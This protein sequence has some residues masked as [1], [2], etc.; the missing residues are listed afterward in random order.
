MFDDALVE[1]AGRLKT[2]SKYWMMGTLLLN[3]GVLA[4]F[5]LIPLLHPEALS[6]TAMMPMLIAP[7][8]PA[9]VVQVETARAAGSQ[10]AHTT[11]LFTAP[12]TI[13]TGIHE[14]H[15][16]AP[17]PDG[18]IGVMPGSGTDVAGND[19]LAKMLGPSPAIVVAKVKPPAIPRMSSGITNGNLIVKTEPIYPAIAKAAGVQGTVILRAI[20]SKSGTIE[21]LV[22]QSGPAMLRQAALD[23][24]R[25]WRYRPFLLNGEPT[26]VDTMITVNFTN[27]G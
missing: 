4:L 1:S 27:G 22:V 17:A 9:H 5:I 6:R 15:D 21:N 8:P 19:L 20:I 10:Q 3:A 12:P 7:L 13:P 18:P 2:Q 11:T 23:G 14:S 24:V 26:E 25:T 16:D